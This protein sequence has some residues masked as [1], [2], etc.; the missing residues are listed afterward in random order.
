[1]LACIAG[2]S[3]HMHNAKVHHSLLIQIWEMYRFR[4][5]QDRHLNIDFAY[6]GRLLGQSASALLW[7]FA[8][9]AFLVL[10]IS[11]LMQHA[12]VNCRS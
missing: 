9:F 1:M 6:G 10:R 7:R 8:V 3:E 2:H 4:N 12:T 5:G 11:L